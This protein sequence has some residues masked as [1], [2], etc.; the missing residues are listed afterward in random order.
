MTRII[1]HFTV[2]GLVS[3]PFSEREAE[4]DHVLIQ[5]SLLFQCKFG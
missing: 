4:V 5:T 3:K 1:G 2:V